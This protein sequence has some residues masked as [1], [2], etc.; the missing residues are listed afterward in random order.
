M[1]NCCIR[2]ERTRTKLKTNESSK[3]VSYYISNGDSENS[4]AYFEA[5]RN[6]WS[7]EVNNHYRDV[8]LKEDQFRTKKS[9]LPTCWLV[10]ERWY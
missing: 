7:I 9:R 5:V 2:V 8:S 10:S 4:I 3:E 6:H 1:G